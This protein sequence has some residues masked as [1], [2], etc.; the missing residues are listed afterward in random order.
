MLAMTVN[1]VIGNDFYSFW[2]LNMNNSIFYEESLE[3]VSSQLLGTKPDIW[4]FTSL[5]KLQDIEDTEKVLQFLVNEKDQ[6]NFQLK[7]KNNESPIG[8]PVKWSSNNLICAS[9]PK[10]S[11]HNNFQTFYEDYGKNPETF[12]HI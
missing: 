6:L 9:S 5:S 3:E 12:F 1:N 10:A 7:T 11:F 2:T 4:N 8:D